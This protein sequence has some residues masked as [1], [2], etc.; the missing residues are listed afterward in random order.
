M[1]TPRQYAEEI[2]ADK[3]PYAI[4]VAGE[5][6]EAEGNKALLDDAA[7][8]LKDDSAYLVDIAKSILAANEQAR[9]NAEKLR[10]A[11]LAIKADILKRRSENYWHI[12]DSEILE[13]IEAALAAPARICDK[14]NRHKAIWDCRN[15]LKMHGYRLTSKQDDIMCQT[16]WW[17]YDEIKEAEVEYERK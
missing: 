5:L 9:G 1:K 15:W 16:I 7:Q 3:E 17:L 13:K 2:L 12:S 8:C 11:V 6:E 10:K 14:M 4:K